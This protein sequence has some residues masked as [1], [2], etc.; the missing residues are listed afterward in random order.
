MAE[1]GPKLGFWGKTAPFQPSNNHNSKITQDSH[2]KWVNL[3]S[4][5]HFASICMGYDQ[6]EEVQK[7]L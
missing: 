3:K 4:A 5:E 2:K 7:M 6:F 1:K